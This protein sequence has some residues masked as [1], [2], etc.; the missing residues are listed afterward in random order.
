[1][2]HK[3]TKLVERSPIRSPK[4]FS[5]KKDSVKASSK[6]GKSPIRK[7]KRSTTA[8]KTQNSNTD[9]RSRMFKST[10]S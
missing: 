6:S 1:M 10:F 3:T 8:H 9:K 7:Q 5:P 4:N 2:S